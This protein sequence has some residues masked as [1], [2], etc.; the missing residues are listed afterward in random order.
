M[1]KQPIALILAAGKGTRMKSNLC[2]VLHHVAGRPMLL[3]VVEALKRAGVGQICVVAGHQIDR[4]RAAVDGYGLEMALQE[5]QLGTA[6][7][8]MAAGDFFRDHDGDVLVLCGDTPLIEARTITDF[9]QAH[10]D[11][12]SQLTVLTTTLSDPSG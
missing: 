11:N 9:V 10:N 7:A 6:D 12:Q 8:V 2:K 4:V 5:P 3:Y 1:T